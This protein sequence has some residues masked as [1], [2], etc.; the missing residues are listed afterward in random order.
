MAALTFI[1]AAILLILGTWHFITE[2][3]AWWSEGIRC[4]YRG[5]D[6]ESL[7][8]V[9]LWRATTAAAGAAFLA[10]GQDVLF[11]AGVWPVVVASPAAMKRLLTAVMLEAT[12]ASA[13]TKT[14]AAVVVGAHEGHS[15]L[16]VV[17][18]ATEKE[19]RR[20]EGLS[21]D[22]LREM[23][24]ELEWRVTRTTGEGHATISV[25]WP[26]HHV[27]SEVERWWS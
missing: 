10:N 15:A 26:A 3:L 19:T 7:D 2:E 16:D 13:R 25:H 17:Y 24:D 8:N 21:V 11:R 1:V 5:M 23:A 18:S 27:R 12:R 6:E 14:S 20:I 4:V 9:G 22:R